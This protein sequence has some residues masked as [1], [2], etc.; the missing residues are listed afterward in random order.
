[1]TGAL[2][3]RFPGASGLLLNLKLFNILPE[4][5]KSKGS[6]SASAPAAAAA[7]VSDL[8]TAK[9]FTRLLTIRDLQTLA[10]QL[11]DFNDSV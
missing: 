11:T 7:L 8:K 1:M 10:I 4:G 6:K 9:P 2:S 3:R 5:S